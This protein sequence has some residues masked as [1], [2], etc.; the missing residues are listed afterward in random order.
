[1]RTVGS[2]ELGSITPK[3]KNRAQKYCWQTGGETRL[4]LRETPRDEWTWMDAGEKKIQNTRKEGNGIKFVHWVMG[5][6]EWKSY[7]LRQSEK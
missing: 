4:Q 3:K 2:N 6:K 5:E 7:A 1:M